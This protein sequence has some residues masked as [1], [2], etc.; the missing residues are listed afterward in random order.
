MK[1]KAVIRPRKNKAGEVPIYIRISDANKGR[2]VSL[3]IHIKP[4]FWNKRSGTVR[5]NDYYEAD[6]INALIDLRLSE[7]WTQF[8]QLKQT[9]GTVS[10]HTVK[11]NVNYDSGD[12]PIQN[13]TSSLF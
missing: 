12:G 3:G 5:Q 2:Y 9:N 8:Y 7:V 10:A 4:Q 13:R 1:F 11:N 6:T